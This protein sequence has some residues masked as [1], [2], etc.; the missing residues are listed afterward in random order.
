MVKQ[1]QKAFQRLLQERDALNKADGTDRDHL[2][3]DDDNQMSPKNQ[4]KNIS[5]RGKHKQSNGSFR[6]YSQRP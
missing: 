6:N 2:N 5:G 1:Q 4:Y 3:M